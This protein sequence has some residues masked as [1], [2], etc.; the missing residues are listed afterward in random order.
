LEKLPI[1]ACIIARNEAHQLRRCIGALSFV[2]EIIVLDSG[3]SDGTADLARS[4]GAKVFVEEWRGNVRQKARCTELASHD[5]VLNVDADEELSAEL[6]QE[7]SEFIAKSESGFSGCTLPRKTRYLGKFIEHSGWWPEHLLRLFD[8]RKARWVG[9]DPHGHVEVEGRIFRFRQPL[10]H[11]NYENLA[12]HLDK[13]NRY[14]T[15]LAE[16]LKAE[17]RR[18]R[19]VDALFR[20][21]LRFLRMYLLRQGF[22]DGWRGFVLAVIGAFYVFLKYAKLWEHEENSESTKPD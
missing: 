20:P 10:Y 5:W 4:L 15:T 21:P 19:L 22:R 16:G 2:D 1:S 12:H 9:R 13:V 11:F 17:G 8:R 7:I 6:Q 18:F 3:S 14:T